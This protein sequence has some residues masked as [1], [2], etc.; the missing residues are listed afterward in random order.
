ML[1]AGSFSNPNF[2]AGLHMHHLPKPLSLLKD[3]P[4]S[5]IGAIAPEIT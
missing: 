1:K 4:I 5:T 3:G 2:G